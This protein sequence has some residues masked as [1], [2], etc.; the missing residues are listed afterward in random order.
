MTMKHTASALFTALLIASLAGAV[1]A[2]PGGTKGKPDRG[3]GDPGD[4]N[5]VTAVTVLFRDSVTDR[6][7]SDGAI[8]I[9]DYDEA[10][11]SGVRAFIGT[12]ANLGNVWLML[13]KSVRGLLLDFSDCISACSPPFT[14]DVISNSAIKVDAN[15]VQSDG[16]WGMSV[17]TTIF[18]PMRIFYDLDDGQGPGFVEFNPNLKGNSPCKNKSN[19]AVV[20]RTGDATWDISADDTITSCVTLPGGG[21]LAG[22]FVMPFSFTVELIPQ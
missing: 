1:H 9:N 6:V 15:G 3:G 22:V 16:L 8:Y 18:A 4:G 7:G 12:K 21:E 13:A 11:D 19:Y 20:T 14:V 2:A 10:S 5:G 17:G